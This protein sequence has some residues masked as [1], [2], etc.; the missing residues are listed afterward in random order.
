MNYLVL[1]KMVPDIV[2]ELTVAADGRSLDWELVRFKAGDSDEHAL[3][4]A[5]LLKEQYGGIVSVVALD[6]PEVDDTL[7]TAL[8]KGADRAVKLCGDCAKAGGLT[9]ARLFVD[10]L[11]RAHASLPADSLVLVRS[12]AID[13]LEGEIGPFLADLLAVPYVALVTRV[14]A[15]DGGLVVTRELGGGLC[16]QI[17]LP[18]PAVLGIQSAQKPPR[19]V[20]IIK[21]RAAM[22]TGRIETVDMAAPP[23]SGAGCAIDRMYPPVVGTRATMLEGGTEEVAERLVAVLGE[24]NLV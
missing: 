1:R 21:V 2:E 22:K 12:Q 4:Q 13:D 10:F 6:A 18:L 24:H 23:P 20:P 15:A 8:A 16:G 3:E 19:Y 5:L 9:A 7:F 14:A 17:A 11:K